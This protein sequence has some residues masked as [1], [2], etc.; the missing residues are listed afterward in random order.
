MCR[1]HHTGDPINGRILVEG[2]SIGDFLITTPDFERY[3]L[4]LQSHGNGQIVQ[5]EIV[6]DE[7]MRSPKAE[8]TRD[9]R[10]LGVAVR[11]IWLE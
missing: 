1:P 5:I 7:T 4:P 3:L 8:E 9:N 6:V 2:E 11:E 10:E